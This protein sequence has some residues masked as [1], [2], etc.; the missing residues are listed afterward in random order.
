MQASSF[1]LP[2][3]GW[4]LRPGVRSWATASLAVIR[5]TNSDGRSTSFGRGRAGPGTAEARRLSLEV[6]AGAG[7]GKLN[8]DLRSPGRS[9]VGG[10]GLGDDS[11][12]T[13]HAN[14]RHT[15]VER[16]PARVGW[17][18]G[19]QAAAQLT[20]AARALA[21]HQRGAAAGRSRAP[22]RT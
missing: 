10:T 9:G 11:T 13:G 12:P 8:V 3:G 21:D 22:R 19:D 17:A 16:E 14:G 2:G 4:W 20:A 1:A 18:T 15:V 5:S 7:S 6:E